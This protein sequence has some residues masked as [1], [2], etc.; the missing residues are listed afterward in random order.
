MV[1]VIFI[2]AIGEVHHAHFANHY[3]TKNHHNSAALQFLIFV[4]TLCFGLMAHLLFGSGSPVSSIL[5]PAAVF[6]ETSYC[7]HWLSTIIS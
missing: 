6:R 7:V 3:L 4:L 2:P 5:C 1:S